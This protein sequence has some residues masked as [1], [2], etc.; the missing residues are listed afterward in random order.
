MALFKI[1]VAHTLNSVP[2]VHAAGPL[3]TGTVGLVALL[4][5]YVLSSSI[6]AVTFVPFILHLASL[7]VMARDGRLLIASLALG[8]MYK[9]EKQCS[10]DS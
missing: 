1:G 3:L 5:A 10:R 4:T 8:K 7:T 9:K 6:L 2:L